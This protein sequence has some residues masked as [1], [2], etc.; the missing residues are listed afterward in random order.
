[1]A[2]NAYFKGKDEAL[3]V[4]GVDVKRA[5]KYLLKEI[6]SPNFKLKPPSDVGQAMDWVLQMVGFE[7]HHVARTRAK[8]ANIEGPPGRNEDPLHILMRRFMIKPADMPKGIAEVMGERWPT[9]SRTLF[10][11]ALSRRNRDKVQA[12]A[13]IGG[14][15][16]GKT[17]LAQDAVK[18]LGGVIADVSL[19]PYMPDVSRLVAGNLVVLDRPT[20]MPDDPASHMSLEERIRLSQD[21][22]PEGKVAY[23]HSV[24]IEAIRRNLQLTY[25]DAYQQALDH[26]QNPAMVDIPLVFVMPDREIVQSILQGV[27]RMGIVGQS[28]PSFIWDAIQVVDLDAMSVYEIQAGAWM[29]SNPR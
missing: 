23:Q 20:E 3:F 22:S 25:V 7:S 5:A 29:P 14:S 28:E 2:A 16:K 6:N 26:A 13:I 15:G 8:N 4:D 19:R 24:I 10:D 1:M 18:R 9:L 12:I 17:V 11:Q 21:T 27:I